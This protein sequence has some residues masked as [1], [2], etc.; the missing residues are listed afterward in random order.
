MKTAWTL[1]ADEAIARIL[2]Q[3]EEGGDLIA[4]EAFTDPDA[5]AR[6]AEM[7]HGAH[8]R[9]GGLGT[10]PQAT[11]S[12]SDSERHQ[13][14]QLFAAR[15]A[16]RLAQTLREGRYGVLHVIAAPRLLGYLRKALHPS[17]AAVVASEQ[18]KDVVHETLAQLTLRVPA[19]SKGLT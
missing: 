2:E 12:A 10:A 16:E 14:A 1:V 9:R 17:V 3:P 7:K 13:H 19:L 8:G 5:H 15:I 6:E 18:D 11:V 4:V